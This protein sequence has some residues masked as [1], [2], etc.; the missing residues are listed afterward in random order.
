MKMKR[1]F[2]ISQKNLYNDNV[3]I[4]RHLKNLY[5]ENHTKYNHGMVVKRFTEKSI[6]KSHKKQE[7][8]GHQTVLRKTL[9]NITPL[10]FLICRV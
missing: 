10:Y 6:Q 2:D 1:F 7:W 9:Q 5:N 8:G 3:E 4:F